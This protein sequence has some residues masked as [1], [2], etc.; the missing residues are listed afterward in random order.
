MQP[1]KGV[2]TPAGFNLALEKRG[3]LDFELDH[4]ARHAPAPQESIALAK[5]APFGVLAVDK[6]SC[7]LCKACIGACPEAALQD[8]ARD[9]GA[10]LHRAQLRPVRAVRRHLSGGLDRAACR[11]CCSRRRRSRR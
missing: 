6:Q 7:T 4:L 2:S 11:G 8:A 5:G 9:A 10:A 1:A 3:A